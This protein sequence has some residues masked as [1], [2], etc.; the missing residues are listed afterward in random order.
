MESYIRIG[1]TRKTY[2]KDGAIKLEIED[3][4]LDDFFEATVIFINQ[5]GNQVPFFVE[6]IVHEVPLVV[7]LEEVD[8]KEEAQRLAGQGL[9]MRE[10]D[11]SEEALEPEMDLSV[12]E[13]FLVADRK[14]GEIGRIE[15]VLEL[16][17][18]M[19]AVVRYKG[20]EVLIPLNDS[21]ITDI[22]QG[23]RRIEMDLPEGLLGL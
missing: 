22:D 19:M 5:Q 15:E 9:F 20:K 13:G 23:G 18:Q 7:K 12:L 4:F 16:P 2:G 21:F 1:R 11:I 10:Q 8:S 14:M 3:R 6:G 17:Q